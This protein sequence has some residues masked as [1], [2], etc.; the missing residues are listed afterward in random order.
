[1]KYL[2]DRFDFACFLEGCERPYNFKQIHGL[3][4]MLIYDL[5]L[6]L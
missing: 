3:V 5:I 4:I 1:M 2:N 6:L